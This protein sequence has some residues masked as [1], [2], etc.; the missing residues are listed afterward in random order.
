MENG[1]KV[2][3][4][5]LYEKVVEKPKLYRVYACLHLVLMLSFLGYRLLNP[6]DESYVVWILAF[7]C[8]LWFAFQWILECN[9][10]WL[11]V[12][13]RTYPERVACRYSGE[14]TSKLPPVDI[15]ITTSD[16]FKEPAIMTANTVL[17]VL[18]IDY[19]V[20]KFACYVSDDGAS[21]ITFYSLVET[22]RF[23]KKW[24]PFCRKFDIETRA[25][26]VYFSKESPQ[27]SKS[28]DA[29]FLR[30]RQEMEGEYEDLKSRITKVL[31]TQ[32][33]PLESICLDG[34]DGFAHGSSDVRNH[35]S[36][37]KVIYENK[38]DKDDILPHLVYVARE[39]RPK[40]NHHYKAGA[41]NV[42]A[43]VSG[44]MT[45]APFICNLDSDMFVNSSKA[46]KHAM[47]FFLD[48]KSERECGF[49]QFPQV[50]HG[51]IK[52]DPFGN[53][54]RIYLSTMTRGM[55]GIQG[56]PY[57]GTGCFHRRKALYGVPP[58]TDQHSNND[59]REIGDNAKVF[60]DL[61]ASSWSLEAFRIIFGTSSVLSASARTIMRDAQYGVRSSP[62]LAIDEALNVSA[63]SYETNAAWGK[64]I[65]WMYGSTVEDVMTGLK[66]HYMGWH[67]LFCLPEQPAFLGNAPSNGPDS[68]VQQKRWATGLLE[69]FVT[70]LCPFLNIHKNIML[71]QRMMYI[72]CNLW[73]I[74]SVATFCYALLP[75]FCLLSGKS[76]LPG[77]SEPA[78]AAAVA[79]F[80]S[81]YGFKLWEYL[82]IDSSIREWW[83]NQRMWF[84]QCLSAW[85]FGMFDVLMKL[86]GVSETVFVVTPKGSEDE[87]E[88][89]DGDFT[90]DS[91][92]LFIPPTTVLLIN[93][94]AIFSGT[95]LSMAGKYEILRGKLFTEYFCSVWVVISLLPFVKGLV[96]NGKRGIPWSV[97]IKS[98]VLALVL[99]CIWGQN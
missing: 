53:Q 30:E 46:I 52:D 63:C 80:V 9:L 58:A 95:V 2:V 54:L 93:L 6:L 16:P 35:S 14:F 92:S 56:P 47:C 4:P 86:I 50:F 44:V 27:H 83:N 1:F 91:S 57:C 10:R 60:H 79:L 62:S 98:A 74:W 23:A 69:I 33:V 39:K 41:M 12:H 32:E 25:P 26:F 31:E 67:S 15:I 20:Q 81:T 28:F 18:A 45:N 72:Y 7:A 13:Y 97:V 5:P 8:E 88:C 89:N 99:C 22:I 36:V 59:V 94:V 85:I 42:M 21:P 43:R 96:R 84:I 65:G 48:C 68:L 11:L 19:P 24:V 37:V 75:A 51:G 73:G 71:R 55:N 49:V 64:E 70:N 17:S 76:F 34:I 90:F 78:F 29:N 66:I 87:G 38:G 40:V 77:P 61:K 82:R 3:D